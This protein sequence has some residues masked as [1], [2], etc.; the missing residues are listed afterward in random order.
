MKKHLKSMRMHV[1]SLRHLRGLGKCAFSPSFPV[2]MCVCV[3]VHTQTRTLSHRG[4]G[5]A[6]AQ[7]PTLCCPRSEGD[8]VHV[9]WLGKSLRHR[10]GAGG[11]RG[12][13]KK[14]KR[15]PRPV[16]SLRGQRWPPHQDTAQDTEVPSLGALVHRRG[17]RS[18]GRSLLCVTACVCVHATRT[19]RS[20]PAMAA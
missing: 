6:W 16:P 11:G 20:A 13:R 9:A 5:P 14:P 3:R 18:P 2:C 1:Q 10:W 7:A 17:C 4:V 15:G 8:A 12:N 19:H